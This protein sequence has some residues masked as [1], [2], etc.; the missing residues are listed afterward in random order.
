M[1]VD[2]TIALLYDLPANGEAHTDTFLVHSSLLLRK[3]AKGL[4]EFAELFRCNSSSRVLDR[5]LER[6]SDFVVRGSDRNLSTTGELEG[7]LGQ[8]NQDLFQADLV[9]NQELRQ[10]HLLLRAL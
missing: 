9:S 4:K 6:F 3:L 2:K 1:Y 8:V 7:V 5:D 10:A